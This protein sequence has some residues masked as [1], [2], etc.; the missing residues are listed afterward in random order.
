MALRFRRSSLL[1]I[2]A[3]G[4]SVTP[5]ASS[6]CGGD[7]DANPADASDGESH[8]SL[9]GGGADAS[10]D[11][12][13][14][15][16]PSGIRGT[17][18][19]HAPNGAGRIFLGDGSR[20]NQAVLANGVVTF[21]DPAITGPQNVTFVFEPRAT[22]IIVF[23]L[24]K[25]DAPEVWVT[26]SS[27]PSGPL[28]YRGALTGNT[29]YPADPA[30][31]RIDL[32]A[33]GDNGAYGLGN[34]NGPDPYNVSIQA[35]TITTSCDL[36]GAGYNNGSSRLL[37][38]G[39]V[40]NIALPPFVVDASAPDIVGSELVLDHAFDQP[41]AVTATNGAAYGPD[42]GATIAYYRKSVQ[43]METTESFTGATGQVRSVAMTS[44]L[45]TL[46]RAVT[47]RV[48][49]PIGDAF[50]VTPLAANESAV[51]ATF[52]MPPSVVS[53]ATASGVDGGA[54]TTFAPG[55]SI[56]VGNVDPA[57]QVT[58]LM[59]ST[60]R[61]PADGGLEFSFYWTVSLPRGE[62]TFTFFE[63]PPEAPTRF[64]SSNSARVQVSSS[65]YKQ[66]TVAEIHGADLA[67]VSTIRRTRGLSQASVARYFTVK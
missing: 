3:L 20:F 38:A 61:P 1:A 51:T 52:A 56:V 27:A 26:G 24:A 15:A 2:V 17:I 36:F 59:V 40:K 50:V 7:D 10:T 44:P 37:R 63:L 67:A 53:P 22:S 65:A 23:T 34:L 6:G 13:L 48:S 60:Y 29:S 55:S 18:T 46:T 66:T 35:D 4:A 54:V 12:S 8:T 45:D 21:T 11:A 43:A 32:L 31:T 5:A 28:V 14:D 57:A 64:F 16:I 30:V 47:A 9:E 19:L 42:V 41:V 25:I 58:E 39:A 49:G 33:I 62:T